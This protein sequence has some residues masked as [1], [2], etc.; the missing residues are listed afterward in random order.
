M[1][2]FSPFVYI[3]YLYQHGL[4]NI[5]S[6]LF[7]G[8][9]LILIIIYFITQKSNIPVSHLVWGTGINLILS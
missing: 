5:Y 9:S 8:L 3:L 1:F 4:M 6:L 7:Y 2:L